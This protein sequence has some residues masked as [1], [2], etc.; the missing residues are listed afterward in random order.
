MSDGFAHFTDS[1]AAPSRAP[2]ALVPHDSAALPRITKAIYVG[3]GGTVTLRG[4]DAGADVT[5][6]NVAS[7]SY[8]LV[9]AQFVRATG[10]SATDLIGEA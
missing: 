4:V 10:T 3:T 9:R 6:R 8:L 7:G 2:F 5:Y 1:P